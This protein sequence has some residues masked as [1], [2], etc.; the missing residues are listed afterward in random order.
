MSFGE[1]FVA[2][3]AI[4]IYTT[5]RL[6]V[7]GREYF[8]QDMSLLDTM[9][10]LSERFHELWHGPFMPVHDE[11]RGLVRSERPRWE[12]WIFDETRRRITAT[13][14]LMSLAVNPRA[15]SYLLSK[16]QRF[17]LPSSRRLWEAETQAAW[18]REYDNDQFEKHILVQSA[19]RSSSNSKTGPPPKL[20]LTTVGDLTRA[21]DRAVADEG[22][23]GLPSNDALYEDDLLAYWHAGVDSLGMMV[24]A[25]AAQH[26]FEP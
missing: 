13:C 6:V 8:H 11:D 10:K 14:W 5:M 25:A 2:I 1:I 22:S 7:Y 17:P 23:F 21:I 3:Q 19:M 24:T 18:E 15:Q 26:A 9:G 16:P 12:D 20:R 4:S